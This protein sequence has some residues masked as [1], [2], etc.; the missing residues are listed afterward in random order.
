MSDLSA[1]LSDLRIAFDRGFQEPIAMGSEAG[2]LILAIRVERDAFALRVD[3]LAAVSRA[4]KIVPIPS[5]ASALIGLSGIDGRLV[6]VYSL[7]VLLG[8]RALGE[9]AADHQ[10]RRRPTP[11]VLHQAL[12]HRRVDPAEVQVGNV[13]QIPHRGRLNAMRNAKPGRQNAK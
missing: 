6:G 7:A 4:P 1:T 9:V 11:Q 5:R 3:E 10:Q 8:P 12:D 13:G 2:H